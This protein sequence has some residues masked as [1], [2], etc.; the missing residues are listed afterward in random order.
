MSPVKRKTRVA[1]IKAQNQ[2]VI[3]YVFMVGERADELKF[4]VAEAVL[5]RP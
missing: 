3:I 1:V 5:L 4:R 2:T